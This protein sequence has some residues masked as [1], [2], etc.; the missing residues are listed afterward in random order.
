MHD[1]PNAAGD[2]DLRD[3]SAVL[4]HVLDLHPTHL[5]IPDLIRDLSEGSDEAYERAIR[6]LTSVGLL[7]CPG[8]VVEP[9]RAALHF[10]SLPLS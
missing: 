6:D 8:G 1:Q 5:P 9:T 10:D 7:R 3:Q 4:S 2:G